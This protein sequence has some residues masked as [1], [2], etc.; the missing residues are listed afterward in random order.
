MGLSTSREVFVEVVT[1]FVRPVALEFRNS[2]DASTGDLHP[3]SGGG[4]EGRV[5]G[6][7]HEAGASQKALLQRRTDMWVREVRPVETGRWCG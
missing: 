1:S 2:T 5:S 4:D 3:K 7:H 6:S